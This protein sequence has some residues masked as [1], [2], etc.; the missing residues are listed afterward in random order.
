MSLSHRILYAFVYNL[1]FQ[2]CRI[3][4]S[5]RS[6]IVYKTSRMGDFFSPNTKMQISRKLWSNSWAIIENSHPL[7]KGYLLSYYVKKTNKNSLSNQL[8]KKVFVSGNPSVELLRHW[9]E[10]HSK[11]IKRSGVMRTALPDPFWSP[12]TFLILPLET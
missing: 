4:R 7:S 6:Y 11:K 10:K 3:T 12:G 2:V 9:A 1:T 5:A 8:R